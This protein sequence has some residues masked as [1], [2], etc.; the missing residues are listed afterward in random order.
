LAETAPEFAAVIAG[1]EGS[2]G[3]P[4]LVRGGLRLILNPDLT[5]VDA[6]DEYRR[7]TLLWRERIETIDRRAPGLAP[8]RRTLACTSPPTTRSR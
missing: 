5:I 6:T 1:G 3:V 4:P 8:V 2:K 7:A